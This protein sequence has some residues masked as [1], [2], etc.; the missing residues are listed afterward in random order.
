MRWFKKGEI[1][2]ILIKISL[3]KIELLCAWKFFKFSH[4]CCLYSIILYR[5]FSF[6]FS[7][8]LFI[9]SSISSI[10]SSITSTFAT[11]LLFK[12]ST[13]LLSIHLPIIWK[14]FTQ[15]ILLK[16]LKM[17]FFRKQYTKKVKRKALIGHPLWFLEILQMKVSW[18]L[19]V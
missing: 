3:R 12:S 19:F 11:S 6:S 14:I 5:L 10:H 1:Q 8:W 17:K 18:T 7:I 15:P 13:L 4:I 9:I 16:I 2:Q